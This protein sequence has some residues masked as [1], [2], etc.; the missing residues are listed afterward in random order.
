MGFCEMAY[1]ETRNFP[2]A[3]KDGLAKEL[4]ATS[5]LLLRTITRDSVKSQK[6]FLNA[7][8]KTIEIQLDILLLLKLAFRMGFI[9]QGVYQTMEEDLKGLENI[10]NEMK[11]MHGM[12][13]SS[14][15]IFAK[16][17]PESK[18]EKKPAKNP[19]A[20]VSSSKPKEKPKE[21]RQAKQP[22]SKS[23]RGH[24]TQA[25]PAK[26]P[27]E[28][29]QKQ[30]PQNPPAANKPEKFSLAASIALD[31]F[32]GTPLYDDTD[33]MPPEANDSTQSGS[34]A[35]KK[36]TKS[37]EPEEKETQKKSTPKKPV[38]SRWSL[39]RSTA[40]KPSGK[41]KPGKK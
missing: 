26:A 36:D 14:D 17:Q 25:K 41:P 37:V 40:R 9:D 27:M 38:R 33:E 22:S 11:G 15:S 2:D 5:M 23:R 28:T 30:N 19:T 4:R 16:L 31:D 8:D 7:L 12:H 34:G 32:K 21:T 10:S 13:I 18:P 29:K 39:K 24:S 20:L 6:D 1:H 3:E 35:Q